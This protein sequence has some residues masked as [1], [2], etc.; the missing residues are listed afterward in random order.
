MMAARAGT[1]SGLVWLAPIVLAP[2]TAAQNSPSA[3]PPETK[4]LDVAPA[5]I[6]PTPVMLEGILARWADDTA[7]KYE[8]NDDQFERFRGEVQSRWTEFL[9]ENREALQP[10]LTEYV[11][12]RL[13][14]SPPDRD[15]VADWSRRAKPLFEEFRGEMDRTLDELGEMMTP[16]QRARLSLER[17]KTNTGLQMF[18]NRLQSWEL[19]KFEE[20]DWWDPPRREREARR[21]MAE[22]QR[23]PDSKPT[24]I[25]EELQRWDAYV[26]KFMDDFSLDDRQ[27]EACQSILRECEQRAM[28]HLNRHRERIVRLEQMLTKD[29]DIP[30]SLRDEAIALYEPVDDVFKDMKTRLEQIPTSA[31]SAVFESIREPSKH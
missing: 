6:W 24:R 12:S 27:R 11:E 18:A 20:K 5:G 16:M 8:L 7:H 22:G 31:Q 30:E 15:R 21:S 1:F 19:G 13:A 29:E 9:S 3:Q 23:K 14:P 2:R 28:D 25:D 4:S 17:I 26:K 10:L